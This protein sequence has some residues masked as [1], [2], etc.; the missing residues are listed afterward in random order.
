M[1]NSILTVDMI[2]REAIELFRNSNAFLM[3]INRQF[4]DEFARAGMKI[5]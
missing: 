2:T 4:D 5:G 1:A 3:N